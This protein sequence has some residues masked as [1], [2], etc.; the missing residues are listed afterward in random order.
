[1]IDSE[2]EWN[3]KIKPKL[4]LLFPSASYLSLYHVD[5]FLLFC[6]SVT[7]SYNQSLSPSEEEKI[8]K[9]QKKQAYNW[10]NEIFYLLL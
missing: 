3:K 4:Y 10:Q 7:L 2:N 1:M 6:S 8:A 5:S 9:A